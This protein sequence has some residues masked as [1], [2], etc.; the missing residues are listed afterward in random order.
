M[1][2]KQLQLKQD[3]PGSEIHQVQQGQDRALCGVAP[4]EGWRD[5]DRTIPSGYCPSCDLISVVGEVQSAD[6]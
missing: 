6:S 5:V 1:D 4:A 3:T 2:P